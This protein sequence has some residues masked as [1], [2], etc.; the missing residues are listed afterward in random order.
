[1][2]LPQGFESAGIAAGLKRSG[3]PD[4]GVLIGDA[5]LAW[6]MVGTRN[7]LV[8]ACVTRDRR[9]HESGEPVRA[10]VVNSGNANCATGAQGAAD[11]ETFAARAA[12]ALGLRPE[13]VLTASTGVIGVPMPIEAIVEGVDR[14]PDDL[15][16][17]VEPMAG[18][19]RTTD[20]TTKTASAT[21]PG[22]ARVVGI[23]KGSGMIHPNMGTMLAFLATDARVGQGELRAL[24]PRI[25]DRTFNQVTVDGDTSTNDMAMVLAS[26]RVDAEPGE[27]E[28]ALRSV[29]EQL[30]EAI[31]ADGEGAST[32]IRVRVA[33]AR[34]EREAL[35]AAR[36][37]V[38]SPLVKSAVHGR[39]PNWGRI[40]SAIGQSG[41]TFDPTDATV[42]VQGTDVYRGAPLPFDAATVSAALDAETVQID[43][44][45]AAG[46]ASGRAWGCD[47]TEDYVR[48]NA[49]YTT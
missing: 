19:I 39:D 7:R 27:L 45:L 4:L 42:T 5:P 23:A 28:D 33:G 31:A 10:L 8:A 20:T 14:L 40:L 37:V 44:D 41:A 3:R 22:G 17:D 9:L 21:L 30:G 29:A 1:M 12:A 15:S 48:I 26:G 36:A 35:D 43:A 47:L 24:W 25:V 34:T 18:A 11:D 46:E 13:E 32:L 38:R 16:A 49:D 6:A 2:K